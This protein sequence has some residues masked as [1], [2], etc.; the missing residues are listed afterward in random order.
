MRG[1]LSSRIPRF[2]AALAIVAG[3]TF[4]YFRMRSCEQRDRRPLLCLLA[5]LVVSTV[6]GI[7]VSV[8]M[9][10]AAML[11]FNYFF[12]PPVGTSH[13]RRPAEL[14][15]AVHVPGDVAPRQPSFVTA[16]G[17]QA[18]EA[19]QRRR[20]VERLY[21]FS[22]SLLSAGNAIE[23]LNSH[24][25][26]DRGYRSRSAPRRCF[27]PTS[28]RFIVRAWT[29][30]QLDAGHLKAIVAREEIKVDRGAEPVLRPGADGSAGDSAAWGFPAACF[31]G[32][33]S[34]PSAR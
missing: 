17:N 8:F 20:E 34:R 14:G 4:F 24:P 15:G 31:R 25:A 29:S 22:Q 26:P 10:V 11:A 27:S 12:L 5:I 13:D 16:R 6:W 3:I 21:D 18:E 7:A 30:P 9:S 2:A 1:S 32:R 33:R 19:D 23:L 28:R